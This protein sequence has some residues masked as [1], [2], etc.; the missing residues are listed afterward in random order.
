MLSTLHPFLLTCPLRIARGTQVS[1]HPTD[2]TSQTLLP[3]GCYQRAALRTR[4]APS[5]G[6]FAALSSVHAAGPPDDDETTG[7]ST[8]SLGRL[9]PAHKV[10]SPGVAM[11]ERHP[12]SVP[13]RTWEHEGQRK[14]TRATAAAD[15][16]GVG[17]R[18]LLREALTY[19]RAYCQPAASAASSYR[20][21]AEITQ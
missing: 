11:C 16:A 6:T 12:G 17:K 20:H 4:R 2:I 7:R 13:A 14:G 10:L 9:R 19:F 21:Q 18:S 5:V 15:S 8:C 1:E 3:S